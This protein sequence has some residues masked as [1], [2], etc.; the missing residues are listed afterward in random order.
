M[1]IPKQA[2]LGTVM[3][4]QGIWQTKAG[5]D[6]TGRDETREDKSIHNQ[7]DERGLDPLTTYRIVPCGKWEGIVLHHIVPYIESEPGYDKKGLAEIAGG[8]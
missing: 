5:Q 6:K 2:R 1:A 8:S 4:Y 3:R 7:L